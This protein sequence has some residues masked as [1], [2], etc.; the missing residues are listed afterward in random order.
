[1]PLKRMLEKFESARTLELQSYA[2]SVYGRIGKDDFGIPMTD[3]RGVVARET[4]Y[5]SGHYELLKYSN[6]K[7]IPIYRGNESAL[8]SRALELYE[9]PI[10]SHHLQ[11]CTSLSEALETLEKYEEN[12]R[13]KLSYIDIS[14]DYGRLSEIYKPDNHYSYQPPEKDVTPQRHIMLEID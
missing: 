8:K 3:L 1:M 14:F 11:K 12:L 6:Q 4:Q 9:N 2:T 5:G 13:E 10:N 7:K